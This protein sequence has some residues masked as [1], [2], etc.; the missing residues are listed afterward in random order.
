MGLSHSP[1]IVTDGLVLCLDAANPRSYP[2][3]GSTWYDLSGN[4]R[5]FI[6]RNP[7]YYSFNL[8]NGGYIDL[9]RYAPP[10]S[11]TGGYANHTGTGDLTSANYLYNDHS[12]EIWVN[13]D[14]IYPTDADSTESQSALFVYRGYH[15]MFYYDETAIRYNIYDN[16]PVAG[17]YITG[18]VPTQ[19]VWTHYMV[20]RSGNILTM[21]ENGDYVVSDTIDTS[22]VLYSTSNEI[23][24]GR[25]NP[26]GTGYTWPADFKVASARMYK[27]ALSPDEVRR[28]YLATKSRFGL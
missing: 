10:T 6:L 12:T 18:N 8:N 26:H 2:G 3:S 5:N 4:G 13:I 15:T 23:L 20:T 21:Y 25:A 19:G 28:N 14:N 11:E 9:N 1:N 24:I 22:S 16:N 17:R 27:K 7:S